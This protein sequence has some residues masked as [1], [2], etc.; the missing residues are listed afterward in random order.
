MMIFWKNAIRRDKDV[1][2]WAIVITTS[3]QIHQ[4]MA[5]IVVY[6]VEKVLEKGI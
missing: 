6:H 2:L 1:L 3:M 4:I 5:G